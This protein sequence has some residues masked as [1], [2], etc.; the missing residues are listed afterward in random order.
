MLTASVIAVASSACAKIP[1]MHYYT[2]QMRQDSSTAA[3][4][5]PAGPGL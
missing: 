2:L 3:A 1:P 5:D 4:S